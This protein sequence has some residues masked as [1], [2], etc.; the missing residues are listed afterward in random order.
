MNKMSER[1]HKGILC[2]GWTNQSQSC[3]IWLKSTSQCNGV[4]YIWIYNTIMMSLQ[5][6][7]AAP[8]CSLT[9]SVTCFQ[10]QTLISVSTDNCILSDLSNAVWYEHGLTGA[11]VSQKGSGIISLS[12]KG[13]PHWSFGYHK[14]LWWA[15]EI[16]H[17]NK[18]IMWACC[19][20]VMSVCISDKLDN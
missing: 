6:C 11:T 16:S 4:Q 9:V 20:W 18:T 5:L 10:W 13:P 7:W 2:S 3:L 1:R 8:Q 17:C 15:G 14:L 19:L 12:A